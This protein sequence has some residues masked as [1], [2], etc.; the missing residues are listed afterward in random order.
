MKTRKNLGFFVSQKSRISVKII[1]SLFVFL[2]TVSFVSATIDVD[3]ACERNDCMEGS[4]INW[5]I[6]ILNNINKTITIGDI[7]V[8]DIDTNQLI[9]FHNSEDIELVPLGVH[10]FKFSNLV[11]APMQGGYTFQ[12]VPCFQASIG[13]ETA[14]ICR[15]AMK[16]LTVLPLSKVECFAD[17]DCSSSEFCNTHVK[18]CKPLECNKGEVIAEHQCLKLKCAW[19]EKNDEGACSFNPAVFII[20]FIIVLVVITSLYTDNGKKKK[21]KTKKKKRKK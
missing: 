8:K 17:T 6:T 3:F 19:F 1:L 16:S 14:E 13:D 21:R 15:N 4:S 2:L 20:S 9:A 12:F 18:K 11:P 10:I 5:T 7:L